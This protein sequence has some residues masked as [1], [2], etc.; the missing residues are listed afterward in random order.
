[1]RNIR[2]M[3]KP[4]NPIARAM[5]MSRR[6]LQVIPNKKKEHPRKNKYKG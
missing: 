3:I 6:R 1:M 4:I 5:L 2:K